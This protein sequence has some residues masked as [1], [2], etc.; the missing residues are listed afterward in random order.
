[1]EIIDASSAFKLYESYGLPYEV[2]KEVSGDKAK[3][4]TREGFD[5]EFK[6][7][8]EKS[9][10]GSETKFG[11]H[12]LVLDTGELKARN[13]EEV[14]MVTRLHTATH[15]LQAALRKVLGDSLHQAGSDITAE[16]LRF[17]FTF[18]R[19]LTDKEVGEVEDLVNDVVKRN[20]DM[21]FVEM[22]LEEAKKTSALY[23]ERQKYA[24]VVKVYSAIDPKTGEVFSRELC[25]GPHVEHTA[26]VG[27]FRIAK[28]E[29]VGAGT[30][31]IRAVVE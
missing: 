29:S 23:F 13:E 17:D 24:P 15:L 18:D 20:F 31:R 27:K 25:G 6:K 22:P 8:Q 5:E 11:G 26:E 10:A 30:R 16:R 2:I 19:K 28:Q 7:H 4:L 14:K 12:G 3:N 21:G 1:M 9:R